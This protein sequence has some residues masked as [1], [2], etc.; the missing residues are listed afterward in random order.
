MYKLSQISNMYILVH[1]M[2]PRSMS[3]PPV[4]QWDA[5]ISNYSMAAPSQ[6]TVQDTTV[7]ESVGDSSTNSSVQSPSP[8]RTSL[9]LGD[10]SFQLSDTTSTTT[11]G[12]L[13]I[14]ADKVLEDDVQ[15]EDETADI[16]EQQAN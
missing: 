11:V 9:N 10:S 6:I 16:N 4:Q 14:Q 13:F 12:N 3:A 8:F 1:C 15:S 2:Q 7:R 5:V